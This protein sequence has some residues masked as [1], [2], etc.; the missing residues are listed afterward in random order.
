MSTKPFLRGLPGGI[1]GISQGLGVPPSHQMGR[2][3]SWI[4]DTRSLNWVLPLHQAKSKRNQLSMGQPLH[5][6]PHGREGPPNPSNQQIRRNSRHH[7]RL[8]GLL[9]IPQEPARLRVWL[10]AQPGLGPI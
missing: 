3:K 6:R 4:A 1:A 9:V 7:L 2:G 10:T 5:S 8:L